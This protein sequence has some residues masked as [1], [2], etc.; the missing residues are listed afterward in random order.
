MK[1]SHSFPD[2][3]PS[4]PYHEGDAYV[5]QCQ[6]CGI[7]L[8]LDHKTKNVVPSNLFEA[9]PAEADCNAMLVAGVME[10]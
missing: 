5:Y 7:R 6:R 3:K 1:H 2:L 8:V 4:G 10:S 9:F